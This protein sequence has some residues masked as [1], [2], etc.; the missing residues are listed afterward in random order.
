MVDDSRTN[1]VL[2]MQVDE[3]GRQVGAIKPIPL[4]V[5]VVDP[6]A[7]HP[8]EATFTSLALSL[9]TSG[10]NGMRW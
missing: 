4:G 7:S 5:S 2:W 3:A 10:E 6:K 8:T 1:E 9:S